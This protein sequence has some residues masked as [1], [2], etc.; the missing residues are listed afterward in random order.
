M[1]TAYRGPVQAFGYAIP[2]SRHGSKVRLAGISNYGSGLLAVGTPTSS[3]SQLRLDHDIPTIPPHVFVQNVQPPAIVSGLPELGGR[4]R[5]TPQLAC[6]LG[7]LQALP[8]PD[9]ILEQTTRDWIQAAEKDPDEQERLRI[10]TTDVIREFM[11]DELKDSKAVAEVVCLAP[12]LEKDDY[13][14]LLRQFYKGIDQS[15]LLALHQ[16]EG[17]AQMIQSASPGYLDADDLVKT[18]ELLGTR[19][20]DTH[21]Q[22]AHHIYQ[23]TLAVSH[24]LDAMAD[25]K[26]R[27]LDRERLHEPLS[28]YLKE[29]QESDDP[30]LVYQSAYAF[31]ALLFVPDNETPWQAT[32]RR[33]GKVIQGLSGLVSAVKGFDLNGLVEG[34]GNIQQG[35]SGVTEVFQL[36]K[37]T[38]EGVASLVEGGKGFFDSL[39]EGLSFESKRAWYPALRGADTLIQ[40]GQ[41][42]K[43][44]KL[45]CEAPCRNDP[46]FQW[47]LCQRL[48][49]IAANT[50]WS[51][52]IRQNAVAILGEIYRHDAAWGHQANIKQCALNV[53]MQLA[54]PSRSGLQCM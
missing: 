32:L 26:V 8:S 49:N 23:I 4:I 33:T 38:Y 1:T 36:A 14:D 54:S 37:S 43:L 18:L 22:S 9:D 46:A 47:G 25:T 19:L 5:D 44:R 20:R 35:L 28:S 16:L 7:L 41:F 31:Q 2:A 21:K 51:M 45:I 30:Y 11:R 52:D 29:L 10:L 6:S 34:L 17:L 3:T 42:A 13:R 12:V 27:G 50:T 24:V 39:K 40:E 15:S 48:G 53:L